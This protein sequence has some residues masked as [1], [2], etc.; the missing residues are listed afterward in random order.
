[1][2][3]R[4]LPLHI[5]AMLWAHMLRSYRMKLSLIN[6]GLIDFLWLAI[7]IIAVIAF[8]SPESYQ[9]VIPMVF[10]A[11][12]AWSFISMPTWSIGNW[13]RFYINHGLFESHEISRASHALFLSLRIIPSMIMGLISVAA[14]SIFL[15]L[16]TDTY[17][18]RIMNIGLLAVSLAFLLLQSLFYSLT[19][20]FLSIRLS[21]PA[22][23]LDVM[24]LAVF[25]MG[26]VA[27]P[28]DAIP[29]PLRIIALLIPYSHPAEILRYSVVSRSPYLGLEI[30]LML[31]VAYTLILFIIMM[32]TYRNSLYIA[33]VRGVKGIGF[34]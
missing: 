10:W 14:A 21:T 23:L 28:V 20:A 32:A 34:T 24:N 29:H 12:V 7:Y 8:T 26:G 15:Y 17:P 1:M 2:K 9:Q 19:L 33:R 27:V 5:K 18:F 30:E 16:V 31:A 13:A 3:A 4:I 11:L 25:I 6:W 22:P